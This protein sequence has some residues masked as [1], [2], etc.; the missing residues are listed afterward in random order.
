L[1]LKDLAVDCIVVIELFHQCR[2]FDEILLRSALF[3]IL[4]SH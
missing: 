1:L 4:N 3:L 2:L